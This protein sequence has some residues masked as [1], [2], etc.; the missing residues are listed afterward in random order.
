MASYGTY[1]PE[2]LRI[3]NFEEKSVRHAFIRK[4][5]SILTIQLGL[6]FAVICLF[7]FHAPTRK[8]FFERPELFWIAL[9]ISLVMIIALACC[10]SVRRQ[11]PLNFICLFVFTLAEALLLGTLCVRF[12]RDEVMMAVGITALICFALTLF[13]MQT[14]IDFTVMG[15]ALLIGLLCLLVIGLVGMFF[16]SKTLHVVYASLGAFLFSMYLIFDTQLMMG[17]SHRYSIS[18]DEYIFAALSLY[19]DIINIFI[20]I[21]SL[22]G[23]S[24]N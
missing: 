11:V 24:N 1:D 21:L 15:G 17:G 12:S 22:L 10:E 9:G 14:K 16:P 13:A 6:T 7:L 5:Y 8:W 4:V 23:A 3:F 2:G 19:I 18:P 20:Y